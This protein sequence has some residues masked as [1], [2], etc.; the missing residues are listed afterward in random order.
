MSM[1]IPGVRPFL[2]NPPLV[3]Y[4]SLDFGG[5]AFA[6]HNDDITGT[7]GTGSQYTMG[8]WVYVRDV[9]SVQTCMCTIGQPSAGGRGGIGWGID[10]NGGNPRFFIGSWNGTT[11]SKLY[12]S[13]DDLTTST[14]YHFMM[15]AI[16]GGGTVHM[17]IN[18]VYHA[19]GGSV[20]T[21]R[22][23]QTDGHYY[24][25][26][27]YDE[28]EKFDGILAQ[29]FMQ[30]GQRLTSQ[31]IETYLKRGATLT[32]GNISYFDNLYSLHTEK[33]TAVGSTIKDHV[34]SHNLT[35]HENIIYSESFPAN[36]DFANGFANNNS[37]QG[38]GVSSYINL[39]SDFKPYSQIGTGDFS[40]VITFRTT[41]LSHVNCLFYMGH[42]AP[43]SWHY[44]NQGYIYAEID[45]SG[46]LDIFFKHSA[47]ATSPVGANSGWRCPLTILENTWYTLVFS[48]HTDAFDAWING[49]NHWDETGT[50][51]GTAGTNQC[52]SDFDNDNDVNVIGRRKPGD[53]TRYFEGQINRYAC[54]KDQV[55]TEAEAIDIH[56]SNTP[57]DLRVNNDDYIYDADNLQHQLLLNGD[58]E[59]NSV[60]YIPNF[61]NKYFNAKNEG[62]T[63]VSTVPS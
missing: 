9:A 12:L 17:L 55:F 60:D 3:K 2:H 1:L 47:V 40:V 5:D 10:P 31:S 8:A 37:W 51:L 46:N 6:Y 38:D 4:N 28:S 18:G 26:S 23:H 53:S 33:E 61:S 14:W 22:G 54:F 50:N 48:R 29:P 52:S 24:L 45:I 32:A 21:G 49:A 57:L 41:D 20:S 56:N 13:G 35:P 59:I 11:W 62:G 36:G 16:P 39:F 43:T 27:F 42:D 34:N 63:F 7:F 15:Y 30:T 19:G 25:G 58:E 44:T